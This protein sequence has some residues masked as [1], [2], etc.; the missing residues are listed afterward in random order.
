MLDRRVHADFHHRLA[1]LV[2]VVRPDWQLPHIR[3]ALE[4]AERL[5]QIVTP[6]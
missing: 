3:A 2:Q 4:N 5:E 1:D 6:G